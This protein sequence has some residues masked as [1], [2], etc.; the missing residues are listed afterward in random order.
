MR[1]L[2]TFL[3]KIKRVQTKEES[4]LLNPEYYYEKQEVPAEDI[5]INS[6]AELL[7]NSRRYIT[8]FQ[9]PRM[10]ND[11][12][13]FYSLFPVIQLSEEPECWCVYLSS[14]V[15][16]ECKYHSMKFS[17]ERDALMYSYVK[18]QLGSKLNSYN[19]C[20]KCKRDYN[21]EQISPIYL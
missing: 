19:N 15:H 11:E 16:T 1:N 18:T 21:Q 17:S 12:L 13:R 5:Y 6:K 9:M 20:D 2:L 10:Q 7:D 4:S 3:Q 8:L 14:C